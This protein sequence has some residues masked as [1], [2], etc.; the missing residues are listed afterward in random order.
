[1][2][3]KE[4]LSEKITIE[5]AK[6]SLERS[7]YL[8]ENRIEDILINQAY[9]VDSNTYFPDPDTH[10][11]REVDLIAYK[12]TRLS[13]DTGMV[14]TCLLIECVNNPQPFALIPKEQ[15]LFEISN[16]KVQ[17]VG[18]PTI[19]YRFIENNGKTGK[20]GNHLSMFL[21]W[22]E[23][24]HY[25][26]NRTAT[27]FCSFRRK[28]NDGKEW[29]A[30]HEDSHYGDIKKLCDATKHHIDQRLLVSR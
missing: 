7:G 21:K 23:D 29:M 18:I 17:T 19:I 27:Q 20:V 26:N 4:T 9:I 3:K 12:Y 11:P 24:H 13:N 30:S 25:F 8:I 5:E 6:E 1:M 15:H 28:K 14:V 10:I 16:R 22:Q 2:A